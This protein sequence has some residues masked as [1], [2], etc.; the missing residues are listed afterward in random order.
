MAA[1]IAATVVQPGIQADQPWS[2]HDSEQK[3]TPVIHQPHIIRRNVFK[4][5]FPG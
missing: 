4:N 2:Q 5:I 1:E 3:K